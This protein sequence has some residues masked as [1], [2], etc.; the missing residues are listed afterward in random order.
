MQL[1]AYSEG[2]HNALFPSSVIVPIGQK[3]TYAS[4]LSE[5]PPIEAAV[6]AG[7]PL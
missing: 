7:R 4:F 5:F 1:T 6:D 3:E 2:Y